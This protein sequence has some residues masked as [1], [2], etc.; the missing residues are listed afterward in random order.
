MDEFRQVDGSESGSE[1]DVTTVLVVLVAC[2]SGDVEDGS[3]IIGFVLS[4]L[5]LLLL[6]WIDVG[7]VFISGNN[8]LLKNSSVTGVEAVI[9]IDV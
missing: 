8:F 7:F 1:S 9:V 5:T 3:A 4:T 6:L 2:D